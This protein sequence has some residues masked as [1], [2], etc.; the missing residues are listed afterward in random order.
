M[1][2]KGVILLVAFFVLVVFVYEWIAS[3]PDIAPISEPD[4]QINAETGEELFWGK[5]TCH[6]CHRIGDRGYA[7]RGPNLGEGRDGKIIPLRAGERAESLGLAN[8]TAYL[9]Q[10]LAEPGAFLVPGYNNEMPDVF[11]APVALFPSEIKAIITYLASLAGDTTRIDISLPASMYAAYQAP[12]TA[13]RFGAGGNARA[14]RTLFFDVHGAA[15]CATCHVA[16]NEAGQSQG[17]SLGPEL[18][19]IASI[20]TPEHLYYKIIR[21]DSNIVSGYEEVLLKTTDGRYFIG[22]IAEAEGD[23]VT[24]A[25]KQQNLISLPRIEIASITPQHTSIMPGNYREM[26]SESQIEDLVAYLSTL[27]VPNAVSPD[28]SLDNYLSEDK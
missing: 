12:L 15:A 2:L 17:G 21:P 16:T 23:T 7:L 6:V 22:V 20:R 8:S 13:S 24:I 5:G 3:L 26:L 27:T 25:D 14:G 28:T 18:T 10:S 9:V 4:I 11:K 19:A 1:V